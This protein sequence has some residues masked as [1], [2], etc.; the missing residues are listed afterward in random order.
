MLY[1]SSPPSF[2]VAITSHG[3]HLLSTGVTSWWFSCGQAGEDPAETRF[4]PFVLLFLPPFFFTGG[5]KLTFHPKSDVTN[6]YIFVMAGVLGFFILRNFLL[7]VQR[8]F[9]R[10]QRRALQSSTDEKN[11]TLYGPKPFLLRLSDRIDSIAVRPVNLPIVPRDWTYLRL[12]LTVLISAA[13]IACCLVS[14]LLP[15]RHEQIP[16]LTALLYS[17]SRSSRRL[18]RSRIKLVAVLL[19]PSHV[20]VDESLL[21]ISLYSSASPEGTTSSQL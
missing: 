19:V 18:L 17:S 10:R 9:L 1:L 7:I 13:N 3:V 14:S 5:R 16:I 11:A 21:Q 12:L 2:R 8:F 4:S 15:S 20:G 6:I